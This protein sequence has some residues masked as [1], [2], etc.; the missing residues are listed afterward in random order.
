MSSF[1]TIFRGKFPNQ[2][3]SIILINEFLRYVSNLGKQFGV[4]SI[5]FSEFTCNDKSISKMTWLVDSNWEL[6]NG[7]MI[8]LVCRT[9]P[10]PRVWILNL[11]DIGGYLRYLNGNLVSCWGILPVEALPTSQHTSYCTIQRASLSHVALHTGH[12]FWREYILRFLKTPPFRNLNLEGHL[13]QLE[14]YMFMIF[15]MVQCLEPWQREQFILMEYDGSWN[16]H[17][18]SVKL[19]NLRLSSCH[20]CR[21]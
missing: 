14:R 15:G 2:S 10:H 18:K 7:P 5:W 12:N 6:Q 3:E 8:L 19:H 17:R 1:P 16:K 4:V 21:K 9:K 13:Y 20:I 11:V